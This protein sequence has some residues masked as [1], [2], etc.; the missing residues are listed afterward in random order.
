[1][2][3]GLELSVF[4]LGGAAVFAAIGFF[5]SRVAGFPTDD[6]TPS[7]ARPGPDGAGSS[8]HSP[9]HTGH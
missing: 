8:S 2:S 7:P 9:D 1:M 3:V 5:W 6:S 4:L